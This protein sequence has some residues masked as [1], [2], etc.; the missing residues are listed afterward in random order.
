MQF[1]RRTQVIPSIIDFDSFIQI[2]YTKRSLHFRP[3]RNLLK[4]TWPI[5]ANQE[6]AF[7]AISLSGYWVGHY[8][9]N[10]AISGMVITARWISP[11]R[12]TPDFCRRAHAGALSNLKP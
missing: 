8:N 4:T 7:E 3:S 11:P 9:Y 1:S 6:S 12:L 2:I 5:L 10:V